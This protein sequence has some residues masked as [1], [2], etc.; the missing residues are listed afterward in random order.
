MSGV[1][2]GIAAGG[3]LLS[4]PGAL[5]CFANA[6][7]MEGASADVCFVGLLGVLAGAIVAVMG[8]TVTVR[9]RSK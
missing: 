3:F 4:G 7:A 5:V 9:G 2:C 8:D 6:L 1:G